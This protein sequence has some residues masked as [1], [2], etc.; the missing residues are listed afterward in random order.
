MR[1]R[2]RSVG[3]LMALVRWPNALIAAA[4]VAAGG[5]WVGQLTLAVAFAMLAAISLT[6]VANAWNDANDV[7][8][9]RV[10][11]PERPLPRGLLSI[12]DAWAVTATAAALAIGFSFTANAALGLLTV[13]VIAAML[14]YPRVKR[15]G[16]AGNVLVAV[17]ASLPFLYGAAAGGNAR[18]GLALVAIAAPLHLAREL[19][20]DLADVAGDATFRRTLPLSAGPRVTRALVLAALVLF[21]I[22]LALL[23]A[24]TPQMAFAML[25]AVVLA[26]WAVRDTFGG[27]RRA[28]SLFKASMVCA[29]VALVIARP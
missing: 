29:I 3:A 19:A 1:A 15:A 11:H 5:W 4:G 23:V 8:I 21:A 24:A 18:A 9:D 14:A 7:E 2:W 13:G 12:A 28:P 26:L 27:L 25:P 16:L 22:A 20:K 10:A 6:A 17:L